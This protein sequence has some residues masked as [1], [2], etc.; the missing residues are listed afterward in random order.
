MKK[1]VHILTL[2][3]ALFLMSC[4]AA[5]AAPQQETPRPTLSVD[6]Q[7]TGTAAPDMATV[8]IGVTTQGKDAA[9][10]QND[11]AWVSNQIQAAVRGL[12]IEEKDIQTRNYSFYPN[13]STDKDHRNEVTGYTVNNSVIVVVRDI[14][15]TG[16]VID[17]ALS[18]G[19]NEI[20]SLD[21]SASDTKAVRE[22]AC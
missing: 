3:C 19:A 15:L 4:S 6:G 16:K 10:A 11:N 5:F 21:F 18:N 14:K 1:T 22:V 20:N 8:T 9:K 12:G 13:Y 7:G 17:A 2:V